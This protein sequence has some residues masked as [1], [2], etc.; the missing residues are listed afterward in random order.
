MISASIGDL[1]I[2]LPKVFIE[3]LKYSRNLEFDEKPNYEM[4]ISLFGQFVP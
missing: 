1:Y 4:W 2:G 3:F